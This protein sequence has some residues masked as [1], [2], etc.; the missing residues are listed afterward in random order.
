[1]KRGIAII[2]KENPLLRV[3]KHIKEK[4]EEKFA[5]FVAREINQI[6]QENRSKA[7]VWFKD[8]NIY[9]KIGE[10]MRRYYN[11]EESDVRLANYTA[12]YAELEDYLVPNYEKF[13]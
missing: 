11:K 4:Y 6:L 8:Y 2:K 9:D 7:E 13:K 3:K 12:Y 10:I 5:F 1:M